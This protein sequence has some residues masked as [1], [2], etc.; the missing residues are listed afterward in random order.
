MRRHRYPASAVRADALRAA[1]GLALG[2]A[3]MIAAPGIVTAI[4][5]L[6]VVPVFGM[7]AYRVWVKRGLVVT[8]DE[9]GISTAGRGNGNVRWSEVTVIRLDYYSTRRDHAGGWMQLVLR[10]KG[11]TIRLESSLEGFETI[12]RHAARAARRHGLEIEPATAA[13]L[14]ALGIPTMQGGPR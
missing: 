10:G 2:A 13:N 4:I 8:V 12:V 11:D 1:A 3:P 7:Y 9:D 14:D 5:A 6:L